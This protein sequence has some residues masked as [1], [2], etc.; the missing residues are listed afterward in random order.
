MASAESTSS[1]EQDLVQARQAD[2]NEEGQ[3]AALDM[4]TALG[5]GGDDR[6]QSDEEGDDVET[7]C[8]E[9]TSGGGYSIRF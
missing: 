6:E 4:L 5:F 2:E 3:E 9:W 7:E 1:G 8:S